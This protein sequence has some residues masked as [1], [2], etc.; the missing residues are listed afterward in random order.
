MTRR[1][2]NKRQRNKSSPQTLQD[3]KKYRGHLAE[4]IAEN[5]AEVEAETESDISDL[6]SGTVDNFSRGTMTSSN[7]ELPCESN[8]DTLSQS[9]PV[10]ANVD[11]SQV[12]NT[13]T[14]EH[15]ILQ[16]KSQSVIPSSQM[17]TPP[18]PPQ[19]LSQPLMSAN[20]GSHMSAMY[21]PNTSPMNM[22]FPQQMLNF[23]SQMQT[24]IVSVFVDEFV[25]HFALLEYN[26][27]HVF[28]FSK[29]RDRIK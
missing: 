20:M 27:S 18:P 12:L 26:N 8:M 15:V 4:D 29:H 13:P 3:S 2:Y 5:I 16:Q 9:D 19:F 17:A 22:N 21:M 10:S 6:S 28:S 24:H 23:S 25:S 14:A 11:L 7:Q 1:R